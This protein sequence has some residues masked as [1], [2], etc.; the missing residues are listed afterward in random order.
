[1]YE[2]WVMF[3]INTVLIFSFISILIGL[4]IGI[5]VYKK[6]NISEKKV[7]QLTKELLETREKNSAYQQ[8]VAEHFKQTAMLLNELTEKYKDTHQHLA[9]GASELCK[10]ENGNSLLA[11]PITS[12]DPQLDY[13]IQQPLDYAPKKNAANSGTLSEDYG[14]EKVDLGRTDTN[15][16]S[17]DD[18]SKEDIH[19]ESD[20]ED[21]KLTKTNF[22]AI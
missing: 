6:N 8:D 13:Q 3:D 18:N 20:I 22:H 14:L 4:L 7:Q 19:D 17:R 1:M 2:E 15:T 9:L 5:V 10:D 16:D 21:D 12:E 11:N